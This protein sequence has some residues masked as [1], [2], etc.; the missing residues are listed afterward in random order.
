MPFID[1]VFTNMN[2]YF[3]RKN[4]TLNT[5]SNSHTV[6]THSHSVFFFGINFHYIDSTHNKAFTEF[7]LVQL[8]MSL[9]RV[10]LNE[11]RSNSVFFFSF[12]SMIH[13]ILSES[14]IGFFPIYVRK[15]NIETLL[16]HFIQNNLQSN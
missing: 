10:H 16:K 14:N 8:S 5:I 15:F 4:P 11:R 2:V 12:W 3:T 7:S 13:T 1:S 6:F 9:Y